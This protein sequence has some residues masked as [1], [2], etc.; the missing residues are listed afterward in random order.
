MKQ[1][2][3]HSMLQFPAYWNNVEPAAPGIG[4]PFIPM[5][6]SPMLNEQAFS[7]DAPGDTPAF[8]V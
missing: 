8:S 2:N 3:L 6:G 1:S 7:N 4:A 5:L